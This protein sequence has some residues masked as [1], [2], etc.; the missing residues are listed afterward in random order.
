MQGSFFRRWT[1]SPPVEK[2]ITEPEKTELT[3][4][5]DEFQKGRT[6]VEICL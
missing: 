5:I 3:E 1:S 6:V 2:K 4:T